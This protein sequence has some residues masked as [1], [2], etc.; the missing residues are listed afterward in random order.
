MQN[1]ARSFSVHFCGVKCGLFNQIRNVPA[2]KESACVDYMTRL[3]SLKCAEATEPVAYA[4]TVTLQPTDASHI[5]DR[6]IRE[7][8]K[9]NIGRT[10]LNSDVP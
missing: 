3:R 4:I 8:N 5:C 6:L 2:R 10:Q 7:L 9:L 1:G